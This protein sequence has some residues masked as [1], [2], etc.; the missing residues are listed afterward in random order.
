MSDQ[1]IARLK[2]L[3]HPLRIEIL[4]ILARRK[5]PVPIKD[6]AGILDEPQAKLHY[7]FRQLQN[8]DFIEVGGTREIHGITERFYRLKAA[9][10]D[11]DV[12]LKIEDD[13]D[14]V[15]ASLP[16]VE[17]RLVDMLRRLLLTIPQRIA[18]SDEPDAFLPCL[19]SFR[20]VVMDPEVARRCKHALT[21]FLQG[22]ESRLPEMRGMHEDGD[23]YDLVVL[24]VPRIH[25][26][27]RA[28]DSE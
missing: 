9:L 27:E 21:D 1:D 28:S 12:D 15:A 13:P 14:S 4:K 23:V 22:R 16:I 18:H 19:G 26:E 6:V 3:S 2:A 20:E 10:A 7:H 11:L 5:D 17:R 25:D 8:A 24:M